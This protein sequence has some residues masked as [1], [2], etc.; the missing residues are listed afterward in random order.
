MYLL[1]SLLFA[2]ALGLGVPYFLYRSLREPGYGAS[3]LERLRPRVPERS[4]T[5]S[6]WIHAVSVGEVMAAASLVPAL[7][8][9][10]PED[11]IVLSVITVT[12]R[13]VADDKL[14]SVVD[15]V[16]YC[17]FDFQMLVRPV[18]R[19]LAPRALVLLETELWPH[20]VRESKRAGAVTL[21]ANG[22]I[23]DRSY[24]RY[25]A[26]RPF[27]NRFVE[28]VDL[29]C[30]QSELYANRIRALG[31]PEDKVRVMGSLKF[32][33]LAEPARD[34]N[35]ILPLGRRVLVA[36]ST[37]DPEES[38]LLS[39]LETLRTDAPDLLLVLAP[40]HPPR[41]D[42]VFELAQSHGLSVCRRSSG[43]S[44]SEDTDVVVL[45]TLGEL[46]TLYG[47]ADY[48]FVGG[49]LA[50]WGGHNI[51]E[52]L[53]QAKPVV[54]GPHMENFAD[55]ARPFLEREAAVQVEDARGLVDAVRRFIVHPGEA[56]R[57]GERA[58]SVIEENRGA[59]ARTVAALVE[60]LGR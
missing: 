3:L 18:V 15:C 12:G 10:F 41:F 20:L 58:L 60:R 36:G 38:I 13:K 7:E 52:P 56:T 32:D 49:S 39:A 5:R 17:P 59:A 25:R 47:E 37:L 51:I 40:R 28:P 46:K 21:V 29:F 9:A 34:K 23:S 55:M 57:M 1:Y 24:P 2:G 27:M 4:G 11:R 14:G 54:F 30:M 8:R 16:F 45:D 43:D 31:A 22:R 6:I 42:A 44:I 26:V 35:R 19:R 48:V 53:A 33:D 50:P